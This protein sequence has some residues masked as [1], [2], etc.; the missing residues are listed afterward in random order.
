MSRIG[1]QLKIFAI[2]TWVKFRFTRS[3]RLRA[4]R[5]QEAILTTQLASVVFATDTVGFKRASTP[6]KTK[7][8]LASDP[9]VDLPLAE[10]DDDQTPL[11]ELLPDTPKHAIGSERRSRR[12]AVAS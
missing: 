6:K 8:L 1:K 2:T 9:I 10:A 5:A 12:Q 7:P 4:D 11:L 3:D